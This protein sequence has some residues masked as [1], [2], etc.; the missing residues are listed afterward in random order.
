MMWH[1]HAY[2]Q[3]Y[4]HQTTHTHLLGET[5]GQWGL[6]KMRRSVWQTLVLDICILQVT[7]W[8]GTDSRRH[9]SGQFTSH[10]LEQVVL[11][12]WSRAFDGLVSGGVITVSLWGWCMSCLVEGWFQPYHDDR[13]RCYRTHLYTWCIAL[14]HRLPF[15]PL[16]WFSSLC[17]LQNFH[18]SECV[19]LSYFIILHYKLW[20]GSLLVSYCGLTS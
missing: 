16:Y 1:A 7:I 4:T 5:G 14:H 11:P 8:T 10:A 13:F 19:T 18:L 9:R 15:T 17:F 3:T 20:G 12:V 2:T 6:V